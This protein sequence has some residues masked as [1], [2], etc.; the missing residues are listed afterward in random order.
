MRFSLMYQWQNGWVTE[1]AG[2]WA[3]QCNGDNE[4]LE[5]R[6]GNTLLEKS[7][8]SYNGTLIL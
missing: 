6:N 2:Q 8:A 4:L 7:Q 3:R 1:L 5:P